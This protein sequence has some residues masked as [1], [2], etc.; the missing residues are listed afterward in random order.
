M[1]RDVADTGI[2][3]LA[4]PAKTTTDLYVLEMIVSVNDNDMDCE[5]RWWQIDSVNG[6]APLSSGW[7]ASYEITI[8]TLA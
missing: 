7:Q 4:A 5:W 2:W 8:M 6:N 1:W 3:D